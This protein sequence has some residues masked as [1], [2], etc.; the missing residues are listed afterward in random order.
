MQVVRLQEEAHLNTSFKHFTFFVQEFGMIE[1]RELAPLQD[2][3]DRNWVRL[4]SP[5]CHISRVLPF[6]RVSPPHASD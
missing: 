4:R 6:L 1:P 2:L 5:S 3:I